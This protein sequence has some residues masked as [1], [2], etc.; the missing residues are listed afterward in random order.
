MEVGSPFHR[1]GPTQQ[2]IT[3]ILSIQSAENLFVHNNFY[4]EA[5]S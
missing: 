2:A 3:L 4:H 5:L 1:A